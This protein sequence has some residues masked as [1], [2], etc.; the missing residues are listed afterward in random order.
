MGRRSRRTG[1]PS[2][3]GCG[4]M[5]KAPSLRED[6]TKG[7][8]RTRKLY[9]GEH[10]W[11][12]RNG[13]ERFVIARRLTEGAEPY[14]MKVVR[15]PGSQRVLPLSSP[16]RTGHEGL[17][18][19]GSS[20]WPLSPVHL[21]TWPMTPG[22]DETCM[23]HVVCS[24][25][26]WRDTMVRFSVFSRYTWDATQRALV[27]LFLGH[28]QPLLR[29]GF[30]SHLVLLALHP[31]WAQ[32]WVIGRVLPCDFGEAGDRGCVGFDQRRLAFPECPLA[33]VPTR[34]RLHPLT[35][36]VRLSAFRPYPA[37]LPWGLSTLLKDVLGRAVS[38]GMRPT[39]PNGVAFLH[40]PPCRGWLLCVQGGS[41]G[42]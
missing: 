22:V 42:S 34:A 39:A 3:R 40:D 24:T 26:T 38:G 16:L 21:V 17:P 5:A 27:S 41:H 25:L 10:L 1:K 2:T 32:S 12:W 14:T 20:P 30:P 23:L 4:P 28:S 29:V 33:V 15:A 35:A 7:T 19:S 8:Q 18:A 31:V 13:K 11:S 36:F 37:H 6:R 9:T